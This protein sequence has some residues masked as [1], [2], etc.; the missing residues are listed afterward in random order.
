VRLKHPIGAPLIGVCSEAETCRLCAEGL[1]LALAVDRNCEIRDY[2]RGSKNC[3][4]VVGF[5]GG[6][7]TDGSFRISDSS[8]RI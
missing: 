5:I 1:R 3:I 8:Q 7:L 4:G 2:S 6:G